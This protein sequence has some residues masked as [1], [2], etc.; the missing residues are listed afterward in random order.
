MNADPNI[1]GAKLRIAR[2]FIGDSQMDVAV[3]T[4]LSLGTVGNVES[5]RVRRSYRITYKVIDKYIEE[6]FGRLDAR[7]KLVRKNHQSIPDASIPSS[8]KL[9]EVL[10]QVA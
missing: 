7:A 4:G 8:D 5:G 6:V 9:R 3:A 1:I 2:G 10:G